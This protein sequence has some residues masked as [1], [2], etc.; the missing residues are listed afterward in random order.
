[1]IL[2]AII[3]ADHSASD[4][5]GKPAAKVPRVV[6]PSDE[7]ESSGVTKGIFCVSDL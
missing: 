7:A 4:S 1:M 3:I 5:S 2:K 6:E